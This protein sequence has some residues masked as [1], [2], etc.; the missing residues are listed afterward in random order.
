MCKDVD[1]TK[2]YEARRTK[3][4]ANER[5]HAKSAKRKWLIMGVEQ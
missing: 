4:Q 5:P 3:C 1:K 2:E